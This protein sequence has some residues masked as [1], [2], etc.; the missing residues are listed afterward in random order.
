[1]AGSPKFTLSPTPAAWLCLGVP[2]PRG[3]RPLC[4]PDYKPL[5]NQVP[6]APTPPHYPPWATSVPVIPGLPDPPG[7]YHQPSWSQACQIASRGSRPGTTAPWSARSPGG[8]L[9]SHDPTLPRGGYPR[10]QACRA[11]QVGIAGPP[12]PGGPRLPRAFC[13]SR[14]AARPRRAPP[15]APRPTHHPLR[16][17]G[18]T[19]GNCVT[20]TPPLRTASALPAVRTE[21]AD[22]GR[23]GG[24]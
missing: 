9:R 17:P 18:V 24:A 13:P 10:P 11:P 16:G 20:H 14:R 6:G 3:P 7:G 21:R 15:G 12:L 8:C 1:M 2:S 19:M 22:G 4:P 5:S 23:R